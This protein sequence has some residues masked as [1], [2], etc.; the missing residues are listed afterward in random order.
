MGGARLEISERQSD[1]IGSR[2]Q[3]PQP[4]VNASP[5]QAGRSI[6]GEHHAEIQVAVGTGI[7]P[8]H[9]PK[10][11]DSHRVV[12]LNQS[13]RDLFNG[14]LFRELNLHR[15][16][17]FPFSSYRSSNASGANAHAVAIRWSGTPNGKQVQEKAR[18]AR[19]WCERATTV[20][21]KPWTYLL[22]PH[23]WMEENKTFSFFAANCASPTAA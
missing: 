15:L 4:A 2:S 10:K 11:T 18:A 9:G 19:R 12:V 1:N 21:P 13:A 14:F 5:V 20:S 7:A 16:I 8:R 6:I 22:I 23:D 3:V 17:R